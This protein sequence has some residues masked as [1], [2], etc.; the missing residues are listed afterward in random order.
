M[1]LNYYQS[2]S[3]FPQPNLL[4]RAAPRNADCRQMLLGAHSAQYRNAAEKRQVE[5]TRKGKLK[6]QL[7]LM[8]K[9][10]GKQAWLLSEI[11]MQ[12][13]QSDAGV[14][15]TTLCKGRPHHVW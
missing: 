12:S 13:C 10:L 5:A 1:Q 15:L 4:S 6:L 8:R 14:L 7:L 3:T 2:Y 9:P 11:S